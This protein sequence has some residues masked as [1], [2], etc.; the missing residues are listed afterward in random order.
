MQR[1][2]DASR[3]SVAATVKGQLDRLK[4]GERRIAEVMI[5]AGPDLIYHSV[6]DVEL[7]AECSLS[8]V[9]RCCQSLGFKGFQDFKIALN[10]D[11]R[12]PVRDV[13]HGL[14]ADDGAVAVL[15]K[16]AEAAAQ[17]ASSGPELIDAGQ[18][19][20]A[21]E[22]LGEARHVLFLGVG[23]SAPLAQDA[24]YRL[25]TIGIQAEAPADVHMQHVKASLLGS[26]D[27]AVAVSHTGS[28]SETVSAAKA[29]KEAGAAVLAVTSFARSPLVD[30]ADLVLVAGT[31]ETA[32]RVEAMASRVG[33]LVVL[34][35]LFVAIALADQRR[36][37][38]TLVVT[39]GVLSSHRF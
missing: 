26:G 15:T 30:A 24:A 1:A 11:G 21:V 23:T 5:D 36:A 8:S 33:H 34:D 2:L 16:V 9:V 13:Q 18:F 6:S 37:D 25:V 32:Y 7:R 14:T 35:A 39:E 28:T 12:R 29:A 10:R 4:P 38:R 22:R 19:G 20:A 31:L 3:G 17:A 27:V